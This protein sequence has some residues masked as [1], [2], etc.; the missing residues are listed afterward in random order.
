MK[1]VNYLT[2]LTLVTIFL[3][4]FWIS[5]LRP[6]TTALALNSHTAPESI[7]FATRVLRD[8]WDMSE[9]SDISQWFNR[10]VESDRLADYQVANGIFSA[11]TLGSYSEFYLLFSGYPPGMIADKIGA[12]LPIRSS[13]FSCFYIAM[14]AD[15]PT[16]QSNYFSLFWAANRAMETWGDPSQ[17]WGLS[18]GNTVH[19]NQWGLYRADLNNPVVP[20][21]KPWSYQQYW[22]A[23]RV[24]P[25]VVAGTQFAVD[26]ARLTD[27][28]PVYTTLTGL[29]QGTYTLWLGTGTPERQ[30]LV[31]D[32]F[33]PQ[34]DGSYAWDVQGLAAGDYTYYVKTSAGDQVIQQGTLTIV[35]TP[36]VNFT[37]PSPLSGL[38][39][40][41]SNGN[42]WDIESSDVTKLDCATYSFNAGQLWLDTAPPSQLSPPCVGP[43]AN[44]ADPRIFLNTPDHGNLSAYRYLSFS[45]YTE[46]SWSI[47][48][49]GHIVRLFWQLDRPGEDCYYGSRAIALDVGWHTYIVDLYNGWNG[50]PEEFTP[51]GC[52]YTPWTAQASIGP[53]VKFRLDPNE[54]I[55]ALTLHQRFDWLRLTQV[56]SVV[57]GR[58]FPIKVTLNKPAAELQSVSFFYTTNLSE[59][60]QSPAQPYTPSPLSGPFRLFLPVVQTS[61]G[62]DPFVSA[63]PADITFAWDTSNVTPGEYYLCAQVN[64][65]YNQAV[66]CSEAP[67]R[68]L[69]P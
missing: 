21:N 63:L 53:L 18:I 16:T 44:E 54:N 49:L 13:Q 33:T 67:V 39:Y 23:L 51:S 48:D 40:A 6:A 24:I 3:A 1:T 46:D 59:P 2:R 9:F 43:G 11:H 34:P 60:F 69:A 52:G 20:Y 12:R 4:A 66:Y 61:V 7:D 17:A 42:A 56:D 45:T 38:D 26:W 32:S 55:T 62:P 10:T 22:Q 8:P 25:S 58:V 47:P 41:T 5:G 37:R 19:D 36:I 68:V 30:I 64:D 29:P 14:L 28:Q 27:C 57:Q 65:G 50:T 15:W 31:S 35:G